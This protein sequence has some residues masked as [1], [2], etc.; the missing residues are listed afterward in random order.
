MRTFANPSIV[1]GLGLVPSFA[2][3]RTTVRNAGPSRRSSRL[4]EGPL[5]DQRRYK[6]RNRIQIVFGSLKDWR[7]VATRYDR[8]PKVFRS[9][10]A[11]A[12]TVIYWLYVLSLASIF[13]RPI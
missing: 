5:L 4:V 3:V 7:R 10:F 9:A 8:C 12:A 11:L 1:V 13:S 2:A 6:R